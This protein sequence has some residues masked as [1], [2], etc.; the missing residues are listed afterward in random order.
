[1]LLEF[2]KDTAKLALIGAMIFV[3]LG[4]FLRWKRPALADRAEQHRLMILLVLGALLVGIKVSEEALSGDSGPFDKAILL[5]I[6]RN[7][8][9]EYTRFFE[10]VT[11]M[12]SFDSVIALVTL[13]SLVLLALKRHFEVFLLVSSALCGGLVIYLLKLLT[14]RERPALWETRWYW[15]TSF[16]SGHTLESAC[17]A[18]A[19]TL[20][21][22][23]V[24]PTKARLIRVLAFLWV[25]LVG[26][27]RLVLGVHWPTDVLAAMCIGMLIPVALHVLLTRAKWLR[28]QPTSVD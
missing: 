5:F 20:C 15:G 27:S 3:L 25:L 26:S 23:P 1:M 24:L 7:V 11:L 12:G 9:A 16:P 21:L 19:L 17:F 18:M 4:R 14:G 28:P 13:S 10:W 2:L 6:H 8:P 22:R